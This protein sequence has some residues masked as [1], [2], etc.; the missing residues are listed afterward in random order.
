[1]AIKYKHHPADARYLLHTVYR[2]YRKR[3]GYKPW[4]WWCDYC[5]RPIDD[6]EVQPW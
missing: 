3:Q 4:A 1:M 6:D 5:N 2:L